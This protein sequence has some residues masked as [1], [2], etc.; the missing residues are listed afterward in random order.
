MRCFIRI[1]RETKDP[2]D[3][4]QIQTENNLKN[5]LKMN[6]IK[7]T[8]VSGVLKR[9]GA[10][11]VIS[12]ALLSCNGPKEAPGLSVEVSNDLGFK[13]TEVVAIP[14]SELNVPEGTDRKNLRLRKD[15]E[16]TNLRTQWIDYDQDGTADE[17]LFQADVPANG[18]AR[19]IVV[20]DSVNPEPESDVIAYSRFVPERTDDY[21]WENDKVAFRVYGPTGQKEALEGVVGSTLSSGVD[22]WLKRTDRSVIDRWY[23]EHV[24]A[25]GYYHIDHGEGYDPYHVGDSRGTGGTGR[26]QAC[27]FR[28]MHRDLPSLRRSNSRA[29]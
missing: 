23:A 19:Y 20:T 25:P 15:G 12:G 24:K 7:T 16:E 4:H 13:R 29:R 8:G 6:K 21:T 14:V 27:A 3:H 26:S 5:K 17:W 9:Y 10:P 2:S 18:T 11:M 1:K 28:R 22:L